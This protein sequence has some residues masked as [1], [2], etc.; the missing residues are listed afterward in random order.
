MTFP[1]LKENYPLLGTI[2]L[3][4][5]RFVLLR[6]ILYYQFLLSFINFKTQNQESEELVII[7]H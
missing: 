1:A 2:I 4:L 6:G 5:R 3:P 7:H